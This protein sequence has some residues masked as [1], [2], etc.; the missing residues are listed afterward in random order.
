MAP[1]LNRRTKKGE[2]YVRP[3]SIEAALDRLAA[4]DLDGIVREARAE[5][6]KAPGYVESECLVHLLRSTRHDNTDTRF[7]RLFEVLIERVERSLKGSIRTSRRYDAEELRT[8]VVNRLVDLLVEDR[9]S[10]GIKLDFFEVRFA[11]AMTALRIGVLRR[12]E[13]QAEGTDHIEDMGDGEGD[14]VPALTNRISQA[15]AAD[16]SEQEKEHFRNELLRAID[17]LPPLQREAV[18]LFLEG[19]RIEGG[20]TETI[21]KLCGVSDRAVRYRLRNAYETLRRELGERR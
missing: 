13:S 12:S 10:P 5:D 20:D 9:Q 1:P 3:P 15:F 7:Q 8:E 14:A 17:R 16:G 4:L 21:A 2:S 11:R 6:P 19:H 18:A